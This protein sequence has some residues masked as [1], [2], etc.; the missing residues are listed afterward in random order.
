MKFDDSDMKIASHHMNKTVDMSE[1]AANTFVRE[2]SNGNTEKARR[3]GK[4]FAAELTTTRKGAT[5]FGIGAFD[6][7]RTMDQRKVLFAYIVNRVTNDMTPNS[8]LS[9]S[10]LSS[11]YE[12]VKQQSEELHELITDAAAFSLYILAHRSSPGNAEEIGKVFAQLCDREEDPVFIHYGAELSNY[13]IM[14]CTQ[15]MLR[16]QLIK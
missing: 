12:S 6:N 2:K 8:I 4:Q 15:L 10:V 13:F 7:Q 14:Y 1:G 16:M 5:L 11:F 3:L 9:Q